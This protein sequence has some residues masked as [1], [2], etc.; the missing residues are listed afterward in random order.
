MQVSVVGI[1]RG[2][3]PF[4]TNIQYCV[5][6]MTAAPLTVKQWINT[7]ASCITRPFQNCISWIVLNNCH[8]FVLKGRP[9]NT[10]NVCEGNRKFTEFPGIP[11]FRVPSWVVKGNFHP[12][13]PCLKHSGFLCIRVKGH[14]WQWISVVSQTWMRSRP[15]SWKWL[16]PTCSF[17]ERYNWKGFKH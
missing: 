16:K 1:I 12:V 13:W 11:E 17:L 14:C 5:D 4:V 7:E 15:T 6:D 9:S 8:L 3:A 2:S 10:W